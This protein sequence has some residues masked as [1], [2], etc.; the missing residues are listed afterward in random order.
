MNNN[1]CWLLLLLLLSYQQSAVAQKTGMA[2]PLLTAPGKPVSKEFEVEGEVVDAWCFASKTMGPGRGPRHEACGL[3]C[4]R[5]GVTIGIVDDAGNLYIAAKYKGYTGC[6]D[7]L[8][9]FVAKRVH[10]VG[11]LAQ[12]GGCNILKIKKVELANKNTESNHSASRGRRD[13]R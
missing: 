10:V 2:K 5:G 4:A 11:W 12:T 8:V 6:K 9:P 1:A 7:L 13:V 3:A